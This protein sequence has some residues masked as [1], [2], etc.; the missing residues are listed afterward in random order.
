MGENPDELD[1][2]YDEDYPTCAEMKYRLVNAIEQLIAEGYTTFI[3]TLEQGAALW[4]AEACHA[5][6][7]LGGDISLIASP[8][9]ENQA[10]RWHPE[11]RER[12]FN[13]IDFA[14]E[15][16]DPLGELVGEDYIFETADTILILG[17]IEKPRIA[18]IVKR[19]KENSIKIVLA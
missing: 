8:L 9:C 11:R 5:I 17:E 3:S 6:A 14:Q 7:E 10:D 15:L 1:F 18:A 4:G 19:A 12:Y 2:G 13:M 16:I